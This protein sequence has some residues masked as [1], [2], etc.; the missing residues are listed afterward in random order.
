MYIHVHI[1]MNIYWRTD[2]LAAQGGAQW[3]ATCP[4]V[5]RRRPRPRRLVASGALARD[6]E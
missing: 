3:R 1:C 6:A 2:L 4:W 5:R